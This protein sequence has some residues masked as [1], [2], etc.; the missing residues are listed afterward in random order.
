MQDEVFDVAVIG[1]G[2]CGCAIARELSKLELRVIVVEREEDVCCGTSKANSAI[3]HAGYDAE[4]GS[5]MARLNVEGSNLMEG[6]CAELGVDYERIGS[7]VVC[8]DP[9]TRDDLEALVDRGTINGV[10]GLRIVERDELVAME[11]NISDEAVAALW[12][13]T[14]A[15]VNPFQLTC[16][17]ADSAAINGVR[18]VF[19]APVRDIAR[20]SEGLWELST[21]AGAVRARVVVNAAGVHADEL[22][23][24]VSDDHLKIIPRRGQYYVLDTSAGNHVRHTIF[25]L[26][27]RLGK[28]V[29]VTPTTA[30]NLLVGPTAED[31]DDKEG[32]DT[33]AEGL[34][35]VAAKAAR[36][37]RNVPLL[38]QIRSFSGLRAHQ[39][40]HDFVIGEVAG[41][42]GFVDCAAIESPGL[43]ASPA[44]GRMVAGIVAD[45][46]GNPPERADWDGHVE[47]I[48][49]PTRMSA[50]EWSALVRERPDYGRVVCRCRTVT[51]GQIVDAIHRPVG[52]RS[53]DGVKRRC[54]AGMGRCQAGFCTPRV[55]ELLAQEVPGLDM[56]HVTKMGP[57]SEYIVGSP[58]DQLGGD[59]R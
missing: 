49:D 20:D 32:T 53:V 43:S 5:L 29:L 52:A 2:V 35:E 33:T 13:P 12:A 45:L 31:I 55:M 57:G 8:T 19:N 21:P 15:I 42:P 17:L 39:V 28:G 41:A 14:G 46:L 22:H 50:E 25:A 4:P 6:L 23:N 37:V 56:A 59:A 16:A 3:V 24:L 7:L 47:A 27:T 10:A 34:A 58:K 30:G 26:P 9:N 38:E 51:E 54:E 1:A 11:P 36:T 48:P 18:F 44:I 40:G